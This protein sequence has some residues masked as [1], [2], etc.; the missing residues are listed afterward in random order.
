MKKLL[1]ILSFTFCFLTSVAQTFVTRT[2]GSITPVDMRLKAGLNFYV[3]VA[4]DTTLNGGK[5]SLGAL[6]YATSLR[7]LFLRDTIV[8]GGKKWTKLLEFGETVL[9]TDTTAM[10]APYPYSFSNGLTKTGKSVVIGGVLTQATTID[11]QNN[12]STNFIFNNQNYFAVRTASYRLDMPPS[13]NLLSLGKIDGTVGFIAATNANY[14]R[15][16]APGHEVTTLSTGIN[17]YSIDSV[18]ITGGGIATITDTTAFKPLVINANGKLAQAASWHGSVSLAN[19]GL[20]KSGDT[21]QL[22][23]SLIKPTTITSTDAAN[24]LTITGPTTFAEGALLDVITSGNAGIA[25]RGETTNG[26]GVFGLTTTGVGVYGDATGSGGYGV[27][28]GSLAGNAIYAQSISGMAIEA[29]IQPSS[30]NTIVP[31]ASWTRTSSGLGANGIAGSFDFNIKS[32]TVDIQTHQLIFKLTDATNATATSSWEF[33]NLNNATMARKMLIAGNGQLTLDGYVSLPTQTDSTTYKPAALDASGNLVKMANWIGGGGGSGNTNSNIGSG[34]RLAVPNT[35]NI[36]TL[37]PAYGNLLDSTTNANA[38]T[39]KSDTGNT[40]LSTRYADYNINQYNLNS[41]SFI[42]QAMQPGTLAFAADA[43]CVRLNNG[44]ILTVYARTGTASDFNNYVLYSA[45]VDSLNKVEPL[46]QLLPGGFIPEGSQINPSIFRLPSGNIGMIFQGYNSGTDVQLYFTQS[47]DEGVTWAAE[48]QILTDA[49]VGHLFLVY[50]DR[51]VRDISGN[52]WIPLAVNTDDDPSTVT[53]DWAGRF[54]KSTNGTTWTLASTQ[55]TASTNDVI[56]PGMY[57]S[58]VSINDA[59]GN[60]VK[61]MVFY[62]RSRQS[63]IMYKDSSYDAGSYSAANIAMGVETPNAPV[64]VK[65]YNKRLYASFNAK[66]TNTGTGQEDRNKLVFAVSNAGENNF[67]TVATVYQNKNTDTITPF[68]PTLY[69]DTTDGSTL[70][71]Y[72]T[73]WTTLNYGDLLVTRFNNVYAN[74]ASEYDPAYASLR[75]TGG[76]LLPGGS[77]DD[78]LTLYNQTAKITSGYLKFGN[79]ISD[80]SGYIPYI[81][82]MA[83]STASTGTQWY[84]RIGQDSYDGPFSASFVI[85]GQS[86][87]GGTV[88]NQDIFSVLNNSTV[89]FRAKSN[90]TTAATAPADNDSSNTLVTSGWVKRQPN[91][92]SQWITNGSG[93]IYFPANSSTKFVGIGT[94][95]PAYPIDI[96]V[97]TTGTNGYSFLVADSNSSNG[98]TF[99]YGWP[100]AS[101]PADRYKALFVDGSGLNFGTLP[102]SLTGSPTAQMTLRNGGNLGIGTTAPSFKLTVIGSVAFDL[103]SDA[104][105]DIFYRGAG[106]NLLRLGAGSDGDILTI[107]SGVP[108]WSTGS[109]GDTTA[110]YLPL[111]AYA[112]AGSDPDTIGIAGLTTLGTAG[113]S[114]RIN[115]GGTGFEYY[116]PSSGGVTTMANIGSTPNADG[117]TISGSTLTLQPASGSFGGVVTT[118]NQTFAGD[119]N[120]TGSLTVTSNKLILTGNINSMLE[121]QDYTDGKELQF[122]YGGHDLILTARQASFAFGEKYRFN[123]YAPD[124][125]L[126]TTEAG[127]LTFGGRTAAFP[128]LKRNGTN[129][130]LRLGDNSAASDLEVLDEAYGVGW[131]GSLEVPTK[132]AIYDKIEANTTL[133]TG[134]GTATN[135]T[136][137]ISGFLQFTGAPLSTKNLATNYGVVGGKIYETGSDGANVTTG[138]TD[139]YS[140]TLNANQLGAD[141][142]EIVAKY[143]G[144]YFGSTSDKELKVYFGGTQ[145]FASTP[146]AISVTSSWEVNVQVKRVNTTTVRCT[147]S[148][149]APAASTVVHQTYTEVGS[150]DFTTT[151]I[152]K[153]TGQASSTGAATNDIVSR[154]GTIW[155]YPGLI[156]N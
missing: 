79:G 57:E 118:G 98:A 34:F 135:R 21:I 44:K 65:S 145:I 113:Q 59:A 90:G 91:V 54:M 125:M 134:N 38:L 16:F 88:L 36:K 122:Q 155:W 119:K 27:F 78:Y 25:I 32:S 56:E 39:L 80:Q 128:G 101:N 117:A 47:S 108:I 2:T 60:S 89:V 70:V 75:I 8:G 53:G 67:K 28:A 73:I 131:N 95:T 147:V 74:N 58:D 86:N 63:T 84:S 7:S 97:A 37:F 43:T 50:P 82:S 112:G 151:K 111:V 48:T 55:I 45:T 17:I 123:M 68:E 6:I 141:G 15:I 152:I 121:F 66:L 87:S 49:D 127:L 106:G 26:R 23:G 77:N 40:G 148:L 120:H 110:L 126:N 9:Y 92:N 146:L 29:L 71:F 140:I 12:S 99:V 61:K 41:Q 3:P 72:S 154:M 93:N 116:T 20:S 69:I 64:T 139:L 19:N 30:T 24:T 144:T 62:W 102:N 10:L 150:L 76:K 1:F 85:N 33:W 100:L 18:T 103:G 153:I 132:N 51:V 4:S 46:G 109:G 142:E 96:R 143:A 114:I 130:Q 124:S 136:V 129:L 137:T 22:G 83:V 42:V 94:A 31:I 107:Y 149:L 133:Y 35:N 115:A 105:G 104:T 138:E 52:Y 13:G 14:A 11:A 81:T 156:L 5:D